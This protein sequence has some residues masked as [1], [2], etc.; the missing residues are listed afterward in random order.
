[1]IC[2]MKHLVP[3]PLSDVAASQRAHSGTKIEWNAAAWRVSAAEKSPT[4]PQPG[5]WTARASRQSLLDGVASRARLPHCI[6]RRGLTAC[7]VDSKTVA[8]AY[9]AR[10]ALYGSATIRMRAESRHRDGGKSTDPAVMNPLELD[11]ESRSMPRH[12]YAPIHLGRLGVFADGLALKARNPVIA[13]REHREEGASD[14][15]AYARADFLSSGPCGSL[16]R[17][18]PGTRTGR[19]SEGVLYPA[20]VDAY[21]ANPLPHHRPRPPPRPDG[22]HPGSH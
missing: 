7:Q 13:E 11:V 2:G 22:C 5:L 18:V 1:M 19:S 9:Q 21:G 14:G 12:G 8:R 20:G 4:A 15:H 17:R 3:S 6:A 10:C 16:R